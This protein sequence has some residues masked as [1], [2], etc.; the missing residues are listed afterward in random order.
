MDQIDRDLLMMLSDPEFSRDEV[1]VIAEDGSEGAKVAAV[2]RRTY[3]SQRLGR[4][5]IRTE[6][7]S[8]FLM[9]QI[10]RGLNEGRKLKVNGKPIEIVSVEPGL[11]G[12]TRLIMKEEPLSYADDE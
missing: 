9:D 7:I 4:R 6:R 10:G 5:E 1:K 12:I 8:V 3:G 2:V 11:E